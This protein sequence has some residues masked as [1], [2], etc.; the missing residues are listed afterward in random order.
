MTNITNAKSQRSIHIRLIATICSLYT[1]D[2]GL[3][4]T[5]H[6]LY[7]YKTNDSVFTYYRKTSVTFSLTIF[8]TMYRKIK[9]ITNYQ[10][11]SSNANRYIT[12]VLSTHNMCVKLFVLQ[13]LGLLILSEVN[14]NTRT[15]MQVRGKK[16]PTVS[17]SISYK[18][19][20]RRHPLPFLCSV[21]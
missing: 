5:Q 16:R 2:I 18:S 13:N 8:P 11:T 6:L 21:V 17:S 15:A 20:N 10:A 9:Q 7:R 19:T 1:I 4:S 12:N 3:F 14:V